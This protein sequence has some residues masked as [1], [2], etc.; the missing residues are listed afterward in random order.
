ML[1]GLG[2]QDMRDC[3]LRTV[4]DIRDDNDNN[5]DANNHSGKDEAVGVV[6]NPLNN[7]TEG[8]SVDV[9]ESESDSDSSGSEERIV[10][11]KAV[12]FD[13]N[14]AQVIPSGS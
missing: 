9:H 7:E 11:R 8:L 4:W 13:A 10:F 3:E 12:H 2:L 14:I 5:T 1:E 6:I